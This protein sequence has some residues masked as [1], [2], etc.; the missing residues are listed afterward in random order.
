MFVSEKGYYYRSYRDRMA[1]KLIETLATF[2]Q[3]KVELVGPISITRALNAREYM[4][5]DYMSV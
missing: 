3:K 5:Y 4:L 2:S 1:P